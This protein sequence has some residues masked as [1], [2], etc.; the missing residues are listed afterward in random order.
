MSSIGNAWQ[1]NVNAH[2]NVVGSTHMEDQM[3]A[4][5]MLFPS[6]HQYG[7]NTCTHDGTADSLAKEG[8]DTQPMQLHPGF[9]FE[10]TKRAMAFSS[11][12]PSVAALRL[13]IGRILP[14]AVGKGG[15]MVR[16]VD[17]GESIEL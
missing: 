2:G 9:V 8:A 14:N 7:R 17:G 4:V 10:T 3:I 13:D 15:P 6:I 11:S 16:S 1:G 12:S 5:S